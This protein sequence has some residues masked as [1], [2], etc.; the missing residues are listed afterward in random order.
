MSVGI[1]VLETV[2]IPHADFLALPTTAF[3]AVAAPG[4][5]FVARAVAAAVVVDSSAGAYS[6]IDATATLV[7]SG[8]TPLLESDD[9]LTD[10]LTQADVA[11]AWLGPS[12]GV[13]LASATENTAITVAI[14]N[15]SSSDLEGGHADN[16]ITVSVLYC[17]VPV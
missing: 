9:A 4:P 14:T 5:G 17:V 1:A 2:T 16:V 8:C 10:L 6:N 3:V 7:V 12:T 13:A 15:G 11:V